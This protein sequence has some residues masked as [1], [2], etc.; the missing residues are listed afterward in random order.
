MAVGP[1]TFDT[2][3]LQNLDNTKDL[4]DASDAMEYCLAGIEK[5]G[6]EEGNGGVFGCIDGD[7]AA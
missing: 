3:R 1:A 5:T 4:L 6:A 2:D 7:F